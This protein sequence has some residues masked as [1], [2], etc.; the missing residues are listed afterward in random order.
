MIETSGGAVDR[1]R[2]AVPIWEA[3][4]GAMIVALWLAGHA[5]LRLLS[6]K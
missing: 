1:I 3:G 6:V 4:F 2:I 5:W